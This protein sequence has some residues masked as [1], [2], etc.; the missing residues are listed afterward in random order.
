MR[1]NLV[2]DAAEVVERLRTAGVVAL[3]PAVDQDLY[4]CGDGEQ[5]QLIWKTGVAGNA[6]AKARIGKRMSRADGQRLLEGLLVRVAQINADSDELYDIERVELFGSMLS[7]DA[8]EVGDV[9]VRVLAR[10]RYPFDEHRMRARQAI[11]SA[12]ASIGS[13]VDD[14]VA[15]QSD[16]SA[17]QEPI[18]EARHPIGRR[19]V[20]AAA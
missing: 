13:I 19:G 6:I 17:T 4:R 16:L 1:T 14:D 9:D 3:V 12:D 5:G 11:E 15:E 20:S 8:S 7:D 2:L 10:Q 18:P